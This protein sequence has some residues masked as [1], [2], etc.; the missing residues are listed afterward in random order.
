M[1]L[2]ALNPEGKVNSPRTVFSCRGLYLHKPN[3][4][5]YNTQPTILNIRPAKLQ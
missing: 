2:T 1:Y 3:L 4:R 5:A